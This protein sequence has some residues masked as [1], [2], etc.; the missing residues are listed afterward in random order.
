[1]SNSPPKKGKLKRGRERGRGI[2]RGRGRGGRKGKGKKSSGKMIRHKSYLSFP[3]PSNLSF[4]E[5]KLE[6]IQQPPKETLQ[7][8]FV[9][10]YKGRETRSNIRIIDDTKLLYFTSKLGVVYNVEEHSQSF[11]AR[12]DSN[13]LS[14]DLHP[15]REFVATGQSGNPSKICVWNLNTTELLTELNSEN[16]KGG[17]KSLSFSASGEYLVAAGQDKNQVVVFNWV[18][19]VEIANA[20]AGEGRIMQLLCDRH[21]ENKFVTVGKPNIIFWSFNKNNSKLIKRDGLFGQVAKPQ[22]LPCVCHYIANENKYYT[23]TG[24]ASGDLYLWRQRKCIKVIKLVNANSPILSV[25]CNDSGTTIVAGT[26]KG[27]IYICRKLLLKKSIIKELH[28]FHEHIRAVTLSP[29]G[30]TVIG[31]NMSGDIWALTSSN[32]F[33]TLLSAHGTGY[34]A[35]LCGLATHPSKLEFVTTSEDKKL[36]VWNLESFQLKTHHL[37]QESSKCVEISPNGKF[38]GVGYDNGSIE[39]FHYRN[40]KTEYT[41]KGRK[42]EISVVKFSS[43]NKLF[44]A[45]SNDTF[46]DLYQIEP[47]GKWKHLGTMGGHGSPIRS[48]DFSIYGDY[49]Q[50]SGEDLN[51]LFHSTENCKRET[52]KSIMVDQEMST[53]TSA[54]G[55]PVQGINQKG[56][57]SQFIS[58]CSRSNDQSLITVSDGTGNIGL[59]NYPCLSSE[60]EGKFFSAHSNEIKALRFTYDD[61]WL[62]S[63]G[64][65]DAS[66]FIWKVIKD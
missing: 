56:I 31:G 66:I 35:Q 4:D 55:W 46:I 29:D 53:W 43:D 49:L 33:T 30:K 54:L 19:S 11:F 10:G 18:E 37:L 52:S 17:V 40:F 38:I 65:K 63:I 64:G 51:F 5:N 20:S 59:Y 44:A 26:K 3:V 13:I 7:L 24:T 57:E 39:V 34:S 21:E 22:L 15:N 16:L 62:I 50:S 47:N 32:D 45:A 36:M 23:V 41:Y 60:H 25:A 8:A 61:E 6:Q 58:T 2:S 12:H 48:L 28:P 9:H 42:R 1:M 27:G 14:L